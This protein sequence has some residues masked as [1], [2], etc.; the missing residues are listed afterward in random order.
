[1]YQYKY[2]EIKKGAWMTFQTKVLPV[3][4]LSPATDQ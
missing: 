4:S 1:M 3:N 2:K